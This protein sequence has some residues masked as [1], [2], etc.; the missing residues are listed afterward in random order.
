MF[1]AKQRVPVINKFFFWR[2]RVYFKSS[3]E[4]FSSLNRSTDRAKVEILKIYLGSSG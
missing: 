4:A 1:Q 2:G 3:L